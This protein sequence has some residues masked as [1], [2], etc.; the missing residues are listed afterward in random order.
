MWSLTYGMWH[1][2]RV[3]FCSYFQG[4]TVTNAIKILLAL[5]S[6]TVFASACNSS[7]QERPVATE[8]DQAQSELGGNAEVDDSQVLAAQESRAINTLV[9][10]TL[11]VKKMLRPDNKGERHEKFLLKA[12]NGTSILVAH[13]VSRAPVVP[14]S[15][16][17]VVTVRGEYI[18]NAK[19]GLIHWTHRSD[20]PKHPGGFI[21]FH[22]QRYE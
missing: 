13:N 11:P 6:C 16:G 7:V 2:K 19:G 8:R 17:D 5:I 22:G 18:W 15:A 1:I 21:E 10:C 20:S 14:I 4:F 3:C 9:T 12:S